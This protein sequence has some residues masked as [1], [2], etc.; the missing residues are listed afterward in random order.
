M[1][2]P[3]SLEVAILLLFNVVPG[4]KG[5]LWD[6]S[7]LQVRIQCDKGPRWEGR[8]EKQILPVATVTGR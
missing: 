3:R 5:G 8:D 6:L 4:E 7:V 2:F 1:V